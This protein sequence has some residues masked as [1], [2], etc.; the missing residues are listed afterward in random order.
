MGRNQGFD[1]GLPLALNQSWELPR[2]LSY[3]NVFVRMVIS[4]GFLV[5][6]SVSHWLCS[7]GT[8][9]G[10]A[11][12]TARTKLHAKA[13][14]PAPPRASTQS[15]MPATDR[16]A[17]Y[18]ATAGGDDAIPPTTVQPLRSTLSVADRQNSTRQTLCASVKGHKA[19]IRDM[20][21]ARA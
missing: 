18:T 15:Y 20:E 19:S 12:N 7:A 16:T 8:D 9:G 1:S 14:G 5:S 3:V 11:I 21:L 10:A 13:S 17:S 6:H 2:S 4:L